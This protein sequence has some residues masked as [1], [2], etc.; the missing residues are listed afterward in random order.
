MEI[1]I[2]GTY[3]GELSQ[4]FILTTYVVNGELAVD[5]GALGLGLTV[6]EQKRIQNVLVTHTHIDHLATLPIF[7]DNRWSDAAAPPVIHA[8]PHNLAMIKKHL[9]NNVLWPELQSISSQFF[10]LR[11]AEPYQ[12]VDLERFT[13]Y[14]FPVNHPVPTYGIMLE[15]KATRSQVL[16]TSDTTICD[17]I[18]IEANRSPRLKAIFSEISFPDTYLDLAQS[19]G[20]LTPKLL[21]QELRKLKKNVPIYLTHYKNQFVDEIQREIG[22][23]DSFDLHIARAGEKIHIE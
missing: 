10:A 18:W 20:H 15:E 12:P 4:R 16:F 11:D 23:L 1:Q 17:V 7:I 9:F 13:F 5:A 21:E 2:L 19:S 8:T 6:A 14:M 22:R 3:P